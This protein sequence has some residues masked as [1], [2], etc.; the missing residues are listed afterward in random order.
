MVGLSALLVAACGGGMGGG[1]GAGPSPQVMRPVP[2][3]GYD[4][5]VAAFRLRA[6]AKGISPATLDTAFRSAGFLPDVIDK[7]RNQT[8]FTRSLEDYLAIAASEERVSKGR[9]ALRAY[10]PVLAKIEA[11]YG[12]EANV[13][14]A[15]WGME[16]F[17]GER[18]GDV[19]V[20]SALSTLAYEGRRGEFFEQQLVAA[21]KIL[22]N[23][24]T[25]ANGM[26]G[27]WAGAMGHTQ[28]IPTSY[29]AYA[30]D[31]T[32]DGRRD[33]WSDDPSDSLAS[34]ANYVA[35]FGWQTGR[36]WGMEVRL[37]AGFDAGLAGRANKRAA[38]DWAARG[39]RTLAGQR[40]SVAD[41]QAAGVRAQRGQRLPSGGEATLMFPAGAEGPALL[42]FQNFNVIKRYNNANAY[43]IAIAHLADRLRG[44]GDFVAPWPRRDRALNAD[45][46]M[47]LQRL[48]AR[49]GHYDGEIDGLVGSGTI[50]AIGAWQR[51]NGVTPDGYVSAAL[52]ERLRRG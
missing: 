21:L 27:S 10:G 28:F 44:G 35:R 18:R 29:L 34:T 23:G 40:R 7:D 37:P 42:T 31:F 51:A 30:V 13:V 52:L 19:P 22:Q 6:E 50:S 4:A 3:A 25:S 17:Y 38:T 20:I 41:W 33:I 2:N 11:R 5:W 1:A 46:R 47:E 39:V 8:E 49:T 24:D 43:A 48:L 26:T 14:V 36:P 15:V 16:S 32:G 45:E 9:A 12:V